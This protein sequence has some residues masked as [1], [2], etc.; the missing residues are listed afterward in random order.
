M[1]TKSLSF[2]L[3]EEG[4]NKKH[5]GYLFYG[6][7]NSDCTFNKCLLC[8]QWNLTIKTTLGLVTGPIGSPNSEVLVLIHM[9]LDL[10]LEWS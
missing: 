7:L 3:Q 2:F 10:L 1:A 6:L 9:N 5:I 8:I 4:R